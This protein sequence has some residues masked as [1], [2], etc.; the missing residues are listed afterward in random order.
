MDAHLLR[1]VLNSEMLQLCGQGLGT[2]LKKAEPAASV[3]KMRCGKKVLWVTRN[4][5]NRTEVLL[6]IA[7]NYYW[8]YYLIEMYI[9]FWF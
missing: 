2:K 5:Q 9:V 1:Q 3:M 4:K 6:L 8:H 7:G